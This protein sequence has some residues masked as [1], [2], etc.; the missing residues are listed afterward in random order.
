[1]DLRD[2]LSMLQVKSGPNGSGEYMCRCPAHDDKTASLCV[3]EKVSSKDHKRRIYLHCQT[4]R[5]STADILAR[6]GLTTRDLIIDQDDNRPSKRNEPPRPPIHVSQA[7]PFME[8]KK[9][10]DGLGELTKVYPYTDALGN[11]LFEVCRFEK[12]DENG[13]RVK[14]FRQR[15][16]APNDPKAKRGYIWKVDDA[17]RTSTLYR[18]P[19]VL[20]AIQSG[21]PI[22][23]AEGEKDVDTL[24]GM[25]YI[26]TT[27]PGGAGKWS[28]G[29]TAILAGADCI[30]LSDYDTE[31]NDY[32]GQRHSWDVATKLSG[33]AKRVRFPDLKAACPELPPKGDVTDFM[34]ILSDRG[35]AALDKLISETPTFDATQT[36]PWFSPLDRAAQL[37]AKV[38]GY[39]V[40]GGRICQNTADGTKPLSTFVAIPFMEVLRDDGVNITREMAIDG[41]TCSGKPLPRVHIKSSQFAGM[42]WAADSWGF[43]ANI[44]P[45]NTIK[46]RLRY[47][48]GEVGNMVAAQKTEY[49]HT[50]WRKINGKWAFLY[51]GGAIGA[52]DV[53]VDL[54]SGL[55][56]YR[57]DG[58][59]AEGFSSIS[60]ADAAQCSFS[61]RD[62]IAQHIAIPL[63][64]TIYLAPLREFLASTGT[65]PAFALFLLGGT[66]ARKSTAAALA[67][68]HFGN[69]TGKNLPASFNDTANFIR[70]KAFL[71]KD[72][73]IVV[74]DYHP[75]TS[76]QERKKMEATAQS[77]ARAFGDGAERG[78]MK[79]DLT[80]Q[81]AMPPRGVAI[82]SGEDT[83]G[84]GESGLARFYVC[85]VSANDVPA[86]ELLTAMQEYA[87]AGYLQRAMRGY[88]VWLSK[89]AEELPAQLHEEFLEMRAEAIKRTDGQHGRTA[90]AIAHIMVG[91]NSMLRYMRDVGIL[92]T[93]DCTRHS[94]DAWDILTAS[95]KKQADDMRSDRP[96]EIFLGTIGELLTSKA[97]GVKD[98]TP[99]QPLAG[100]PAP[101][102][103]REMIGY[104]D[105]EYYYLMPKLAY[106]AVARICN[107]Q[108]QAFP[109]TLKM[110][111]KQMREDKI[112]KFEKDGE[113]TRPKWID[114]RTM[115][116]LWI[117]RSLLDGP[118]TE[119]EQ[120]KMDL[121]S[122]DGFHPANDVEIP[123]QW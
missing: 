93:E 61:L 57:L 92:R 21:T 18:L 103:P 87:R 51:Q 86:T 102:A 112:I 98:I 81:E 3:T 23:V 24:V 16:P 42:G 85:N 78:R 88:I 95:S 15:T 119:S 108:G 79:S 68:S 107:D 45:G 43:A 25:G 6:L 34:E 52:S 35:R 48:I 123:D 29:H 41:W 120:T 54:G 47:V 65:A 71:L 22:F 58:S 122:L 115:R 101:S 31:K 2:F 60:L 53:T 84:I 26:A 75:V 70:K 17:L 77:L 20:A 76:L 38:P 96:T 80:L 67:L 111:Y 50:G 5:C 109:L 4:K 63:L 73:P 100:A 116:L 113:P 94:L 13:K 33:T 59:G 12:K 1:M 11:P 114:G 36:P 66:G 19:D 110:L 56:A 118:K 69:F 49:T 39:C 74:D 14:T 7:K 117:P 64:G 62:C 90:E 8:P 44:M 27:N 32:A 28:D 10:G 121:H 72:C 89:Q 30:V 83:P 40:E 99:S 97:V 55:S 106:R 91:Y 104:M 37:Y 82:I 9:K 46:D 105:A